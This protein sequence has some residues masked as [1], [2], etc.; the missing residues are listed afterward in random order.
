MKTQ[1]EILSFTEA[2]IL[3]K[4]A[5]YLN[6]I[7]FNLA[8]I[9]IINGSYL[10]MPLMP[11]ASSILVFDKALLDKFITEEHFPVNDNVNA[12][13]HKNKTTVDNLNDLKVNMIQELLINSIYKEDREQQIKLKSNDIDLI[14]QKLKQAKKL[15]KYKLN[16]IVLT[17]EYIINNLRQ[18]E[19]DWGVLKNKQLLNPIINLILVKAASNTYYNIQEALFGKWKYQ[20]IEELLKNIHRDSKQSNEIEYIE[21]K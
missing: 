3:K 4:Q 14:Y 20:G 18:D 12:W 10:V 19:W 8:K 17:G 6:S 9:Y 16:F 5:K 15:T 11:F 7:E 21:R 1:Y 13:Y 2:A